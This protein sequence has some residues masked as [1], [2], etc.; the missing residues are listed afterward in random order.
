MVKHKIQI[1]LS[2]PLIW[3]M[4]PKITFVSKDVVEMG[5]NSAVLHF[6]DGRNGMLKVLQ[7]FDIQ[8]NVT[9]STLSFA[10]NLRI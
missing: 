8:G 6:N 4:V 5:V 2:I 3:S 10:D 7:H 1:K 9:Q